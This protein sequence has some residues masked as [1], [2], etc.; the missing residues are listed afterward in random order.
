MLTEKNI[1]KKIF[2]IG[3]I[4]II[5]LIGVA[6]A[7]ESLPLAKI[8]KNVVETIT[9]EQGY[10]VSIVQKVSQAGK[11]VSKRA[12]VPSTSSFTV[13]YDPTKGVFTKDTDNDKAAKS[14]P[15]IT[16]T[17]EQQ[18]NIKITM[19][20]GKFMNE[21]LTWNDVKT[22]DAKLRGRS[23]YK[24]SGQAGPKGIS[25]TL[26]IDKGHMYISKI[27]T[28]INGKEFSESNIK[29]RLVNNKYWLPAELTIK[30]KSDG[31]EVLQ[32]F[33]EYIFSK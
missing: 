5:L 14:S 1:N 26:W 7:Q 11:R 23:C 21:L 24:I 25:S 16:A 30:H 19:D 31:T 20:I 12:A 2:S 32:K 9:P 18:P 4:T 17:T 33:G 10:S 29:Y 27:I 15:R 3:L 13:F 6:S 8:V 28:G 22:S